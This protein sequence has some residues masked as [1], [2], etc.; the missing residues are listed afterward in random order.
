MSSPLVLKPTLSN[1]WHSIIFR[2][3]DNQTL[4]TWSR[5]M[6]ILTLLD[7]LKVCRKWHSVAANYDFLQLFYNLLI[8]TCKWN[9]LLK[10]NTFSAYSSCPCPIFQL[11]PVFSIFLLIV[12]HPNIPAFALSPMFSISTFLSIATNCQAQLQLQL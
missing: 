7:F 12:F 3:S 8:S 2:Q 5:I 9:C 6:L 1:F 10:L 11:F 4:D